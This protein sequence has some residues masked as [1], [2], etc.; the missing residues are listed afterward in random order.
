MAV[1]SLRSGKGWKIPLL[2]LAALLVLNGVWV[3]VQEWRVARVHADLRARGL[4]VTAEE[5]NDFYTARAGVAVGAADNAAVVYERAFGVMRERENEIDRAKELM[6]PKGVSFGLGHL[7]D[8]EIVE[9]RGLVDSLDEGFELTAE[10]VSMTGA[11]FPID[12]AEEE[13]LFEVLLPHLSQLREVGRVVSWRY[14]LAVRDGEL[15]EAVETL[16]VLDRISA[17]VAAEPVLIS[18][19]VGLSFRRLALDCLEVGVNR[20]VDDVEAVERLRGTLDE[21]DWRERL[22]VGMYGELVVDDDYVSYWETTVDGIRW[23]SGQQQWERRWLVE[24][25]EGVDE[26]LNQVRVMNDGSHLKQAVPMGLLRGDDADSQKDAES[27]IEALWVVEARE[28]LME[29]VV[30]AVW[31][32][33]D[34]GRWPGGEGDLVPGYLAEWSGDPFSVSGG[35]R[36]KGL[37]DGVMF[38]SVGK[39]GVDDGG[40]R[41][42]PGVF[43]DEGVD[44]VVEVFG[45]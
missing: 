35:M 20:W 6:S 27:A 23:W 17:A 7:S 14:L 16:R 26:I 8:E 37:G 22:M 36:M 41:K 3:G 25:F 11:R 13:R 21:V 24:R 10:A 33:A 1:F 32:R 43:S 45:E 40:V 30:A 38:Y 9:L 4:P 44:L 2:V 29:L 31:F 19:L 18:Q 12:F 28:V 42:M 34:E 15:D 5:L 39:D